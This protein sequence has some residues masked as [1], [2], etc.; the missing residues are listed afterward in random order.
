MSRKNY[1]S[2]LFLI[3]LTLTGYSLQAKNYEQYPCIVGVG[4]CLIDRSQAKS[5]SCDA[6]IDPSSWS[7]ETH[8]MV[9][10]KK[11]RSHKGCS[12]ANFTFPQKYDSKAK[13]QYPLCIIVNNKE[14]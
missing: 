4:E 1:L 10:I 14:Q 7:L 5:C 13:Y 2:I 8:K 9:D 12:A 3:P 6:V 11:I